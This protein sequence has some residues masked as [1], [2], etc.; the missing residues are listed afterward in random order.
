MSIYLRKAEIRGSTRAILPTTTLR[1]NMA[2]Q[3]GASLDF[4]VLG[5]NSGTSMDGIDCAL[6]HFW[7]ASP[8][9]PMN[10]E[11]VEVD[12]GRKWYEG[13]R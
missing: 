13:L 12:V 6:C 1:V 7:Q 9:Q 10:F 3:S 4:H 5:L 11:L 8:E 2:S